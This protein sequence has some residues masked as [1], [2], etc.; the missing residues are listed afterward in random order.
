MPLNDTGDKQAQ[1]RLANTH[2]QFWRN[3]LAYRLTQH[4]YEEWDA[5]PTLPFQQP[6]F[7]RDCATLFT[8]IYGLPMAVDCFLWHPH[9]YP[10]GL[11]IATKYQE[12][13]GSV[14][15]KFPFIVANLKAL[16]IPTV[17]LL[18]GGGARPEAIQ[19]CRTQQD[20]FLRVFS[21]W[22][23]WTAALHKGLI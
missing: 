14:D 19:W 3:D 4:G 1:G 11:V 23:E 15:E 17:L 10:K 9:R 5:P 22:E 21:T 7:V 18:I 16:G 20:E 6:F 8:T 12:T 2:G 13:S